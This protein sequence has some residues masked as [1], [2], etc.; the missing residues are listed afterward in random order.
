LCAD[1]RDERP[2]RGEIRAGEEPRGAR[3]L[4]TG[5][6]HRPRFE[7]GGALVVHLRMTG[8][9]PPSGRRTSALIQLD[10]GH[11]LVYWDVVFGIGPRWR[12]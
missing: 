4:A 12:S 11:E 5:G 3:A 10:D 6:K 8:G 2:T 9:F 1:I 7:S